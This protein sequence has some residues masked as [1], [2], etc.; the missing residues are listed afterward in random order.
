[1]REE[2]RAIKGFSHY[3]VSNYGRAMNSHL[4]VLKPYVN[5]KGYLKIQLRD[6]EGN[7]C[8]RRVHRLVAD[9]FLPNEAN[10]PEV[11]H[12]NFD[13]KDNRVENLEWVTGEENREHY[14][15]HR[16]KVSNV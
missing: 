10:R 9:A 14:L 1:M 13:K 12:L 8:K 3:F 5:Q 11:N 4:E 6:D 16:K 7:N 15:A 2:W